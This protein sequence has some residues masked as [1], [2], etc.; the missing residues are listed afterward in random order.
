MAQT[1]LP[2]TEGERLKKKRARKGRQE[3]EMTGDCVGREREE[4]LKKYEL[5]YDLTAGS[6]NKG[7]DCKQD[8][9]Y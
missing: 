3:G 1:V 2:I 9:V 5:V 7:K 6:I 8:V 4:G